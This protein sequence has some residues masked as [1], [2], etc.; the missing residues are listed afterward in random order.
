M[1]WAPL[2]GAA[3]LKDLPTLDHRL[4]QQ[5]KQQQQHRTT[6]PSEM[7]TEAQMQEILEVMKQQMAQMTL[8][9]TENTRLREAADAAAR[10][11][12]PSTPAPTTNG[13]DG[14]VTNTPYR[15]KRP[16]RPVINAALDDREW[17][18]FEDTWV[19]YKTMIN[20]T[21]GCRCH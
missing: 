6:T 18:L 11:A 16:D 4:E 20:V 15:S 7:A 12:A 19:R 1:C 8:L 14:T 5:Q 10:T 2:H 3:N 13:S 9:H 17:A 21:D